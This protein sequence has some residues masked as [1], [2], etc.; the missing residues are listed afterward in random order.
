MPLRYGNGCVHRRRFGG[1]GLPCAPNGRLPVCATAFAAGH[2]RVV[3]FTPPVLPAEV[4]V[5]LPGPNCVK[6][7]V[8][9]GGSLSKAPRRDVYE[10][11]FLPISFENPPLYPRPCMTNSHARC[12][13]FQAINSHSPSV[14]SDEAPH[15]SSRGSPTFPECWRP[16]CLCRG[17]R[18]AAPHP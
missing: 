17:V 16:H 11:S 13:C 12:T 3:P 5:L 15:L 6:S 18:H 1:F 9:L 7:P 14:D 10:R 4:Q 2:W 8:D